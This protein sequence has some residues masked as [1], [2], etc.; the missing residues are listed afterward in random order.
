AE[1]A[2]VPDGSTEQP[3][4][5]D[6]GERPDGEAEPDP[7][8]DTPGTG[9]TLTGER[10][11]GAA[12]AGWGC[13]PSPCPSPGAPTE[14]GS[15]TSSD[16]DAEGLRRRR[17]RKPLPRPPPDPPRGPPASGGED[18]LGAGKCLLGALALVAVGLLAVSGEWVPG[19]AALRAR[20]GHPR[21]PPPRPSL[22]QD[23]QQEPLPPDAGDAWSVPA[24]SL[25][26]DKLAKENQE[27]RL[28][29]AEL[30][31]HKEELQ[32]LL[33]KS[34]GKAAAA[35]MQQ[36]SLTAEN[37][38]LRAALEQEAAALR[39]ARAELQR[40]RAA[41]AAGGPGAGEPTA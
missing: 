15:R 34:E 16:D 27:I 6:G 2:T 14:E 35:G 36:E 23:S 19:A 5:P 10:P 33:R 31:A 40:L 29:Q 11:G 38:Q 37:A 1:A 17:G 30:Q 22:P 26:L 13:G 3:G 28:M 39:D 20:A 25:L 21:L 12:L 41:G 24:V 18:G 8:P 4:V 32:A 7:H 9:Q